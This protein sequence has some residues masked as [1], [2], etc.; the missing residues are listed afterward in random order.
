M[1]RTRRRTL[2]GN[3]GQAF[4]G[5]PGRAGTSGHGHSLATDDSSSAGGVSDCGLHLTSRS[6]GQCLCTPCRGI[7]LHIGT[8]GDVDLLHAGHGGAS[9]GGINGSSLNDIQGILTSTA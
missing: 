7:R 2:D 4:A 6:N 9:S 3:G 5:D 1:I 8:A